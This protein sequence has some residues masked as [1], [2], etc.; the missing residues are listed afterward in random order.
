MMQSWPNLRY[1]PGIVLEWMRKTTKILS[2]D[3]RSLGRDLDSET[4]GREA[5]VLNTLLRRSLYKLYD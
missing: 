1:Y 2:Q 5:G 4:P 3:S